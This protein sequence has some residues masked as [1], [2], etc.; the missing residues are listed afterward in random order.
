MKRRR[1]LIIMPTSRTRPTIPRL[2]SLDE[3]I[4]TD[5]A[6]RCPAEHLAQ[7][8][9]AKGAPVW[10]YEFDAAP[11]GGKT[12]H[13]AEIGYAFGDFELRSGPV[14]EALLD[15]LHANRRS[16]RAGLAAMAAASRAQERSSTC[17][18]TPKASPS[19]GRFARNSARWRTACEV[20]PPR[21]VPRR[22]RRAG[23]ARFGRRLGEAEDRRQV[24]TGTAG[25]AA[26]SAGTSG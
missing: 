23:D 11:N 9:A 8:L 13:A 3:Q 25:S 2:G 16:E 18:S 21:P 26:G 19:K 14:A 24:P 22:A 6:F 7:L 10:R 5:I 15:R 20:R 17:C 12:S 1:A 4:G